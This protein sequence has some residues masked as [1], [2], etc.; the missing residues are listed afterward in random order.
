VPRT[1]DGAGWPTGRIVTEQSS[2][3]ILIW[4]GRLVDA[5]PRVDGGCGP[6][7]RE[8][9]RS[10]AARGI[11]TFAEVGLEPPEVVDVLAR[12]QQHERGPPPPVRG[13]ARR[14]GAA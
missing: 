10:S 12:P 1:P 11:G 5:V 7:R 6:H 9:P 8:L 3:S 4:N 2:E 14:R 13:R